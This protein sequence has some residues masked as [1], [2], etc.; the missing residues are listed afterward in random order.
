MT[1]PWFRTEKYG[2]GWTPASIEGW[3]ALAAFVAGV[4]LDVVVL[5]HR[6]DHG[7]PVF[8]ALVLFYLWLAALVVAPIV[9]WRKTGEP[10][11]WLWVREHEHPQS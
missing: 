3:L 6:P 9:A 2:W 4:A 7:V 8:R 10:P 5:R 11:R 1:R